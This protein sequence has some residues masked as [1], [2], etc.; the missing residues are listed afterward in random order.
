MIVWCV[1]DTI[2]RSVLSSTCTA[3]PSSHKTLTACYTINDDEYLMKRILALLAPSEAAT[4]LHACPGSSINP[5]ERKLL[6][7]TYCVGDES[8]C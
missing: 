7:D 8:N 5:Q 2:R 4:I 6:Y 1:Q 3:A